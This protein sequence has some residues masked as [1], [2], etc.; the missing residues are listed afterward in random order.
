M[1]RRVLHVT[2]VAPPGLGGIETALATL[3]DAMPDVQ[4]TLISPAHARGGDRKW[5]SNVT[6]RTI[7]AGNAV[8]RVVSAVVPPGK[9]KYVALA[10]WLVDEWYRRE[11]ASAMEGDL[12]H[13][14]SFAAFR[15]FA[16][17]RS[18]HPSRLSQSLVD[19]LR[20]FD[21]YGHPLLFTDHSLFGGSREQFDSI[22]NDLLL[23]RLTNVVCVER[24]GKANVDALARERGLRVRAWWIPNPVDTERFRPAPLPS[25][26]RLIVGYAG[27]YERLGTD[28]VLRLAAEA[29]DWVEFRLAFAATEDQIRDAG[30][31]AG[32]TRATLSWNLPNAQMPEFYGSVHLFLDPWSFGAPRTSL[33]ALACGRVVI[34]LAGDGARSAELPVDVSPIVD[35]S[36]PAIFFQALSKLRERSI[37]E[38]LG[39]ASR[40][41]AEDTFSI[42]E[43]AQA[44]RSVYL[45]VG[46]PAT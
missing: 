40:K 9:R 37:L 43:V 27:R 25:T 7:G 22:R 30:A 35:A 4:V 26:D 16:N 18:R 29:P 24:S 5:G 15:Y 41:L 45:A 2:D 32:R 8:R 33:E 1:V 20:F 12:V 44:Y 23:E 17:F 36:D 11:V 38:S 19:W 3:I 28:R 46:G 6:L 21:G 13:L 31:E 39:R 42:R 34:R 14:H 10:S